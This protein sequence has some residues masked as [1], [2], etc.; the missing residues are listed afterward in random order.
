MNENIP[1]K[2]IQYDLE[3]TY[4]KSKVKHINN[5]NNMNKWFYLP[6]AG[7]VVNK[8]IFLCYKMNDHQDH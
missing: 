3:P 7:K 4:Y 1:I 8:L 5:L 6:I 2:I